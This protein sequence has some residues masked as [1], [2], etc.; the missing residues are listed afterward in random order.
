VPLT[1]TQSGGTVIVTFN[2]PTAGTYFILIKYNSGSV[3][4][5]PAPSPTTAVHYD[6]MTTGMPAST[7]GLDLIRH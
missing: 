1:I 6:F 7:S 2:A 5:K 3:K 4:N